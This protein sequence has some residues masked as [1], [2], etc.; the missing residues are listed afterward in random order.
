MIAA[1]PVLTLG[2]HVEDELNDIPSDQTGDSR[3][4]NTI[5]PAVYGLQLKTQEADLKLLTN[6]IKRTTQFNAIRGC[7]II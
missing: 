6:R 5:F 2:R 1:E 4:I 7:Y 3:F